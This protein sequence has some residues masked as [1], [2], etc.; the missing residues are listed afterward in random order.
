[1]NIGLR[2]QSLRKRRG[3]SQEELA[4]KLYVSRQTVSQW[5]T[6]QTMPSIDNIT[7]LH[8]V[9]DVS[10]DELMS[11][12]QPKGK[13][14]ACEWLEMKLDAGERK[15]AFAF[16]YTGLYVK[17]AIVLDMLVWVIVFACINGAEYFSWDRGMIIGVLAVFAFMYT[18]VAL[19]VRK[20]RIAAD[21][22][23]RYSRYRVCG[24]RLDVEL[25]EHGEAVETV[26]V[27]IEEITNLRQN[28]SVLVFTARNRTFML[29]AAKMADAVELKRFFSV[30]EGNRTR[31]IASQ[32]RW[33]KVVSVLLMVFSFIAP[34]FAL[35]M[36]GILQSAHSDYLNMND[37]MWT[38]FIAAVLPAASIAF[39]I[40]QRKKGIH[41][42]RNLVVGLIMFVIMC[43]FGCF[44]FMPIG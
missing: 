8:E 40:W 34:L 20:M 28:S 23:Q 6:G 3:M 1:M 4:E 15:R 41:N 9:L 2:I 21:K 5:E 32:K 7:R 22:A 10:F 26:T 27:N 37:Y 29:S 44:V 43:L 39:A 33:E 18:G 42:V 30:V 17:L 11:E 38:F 24:D 36:N 14:E 25:C 12:E 13:F 31:T 19:R 35:S 16:T